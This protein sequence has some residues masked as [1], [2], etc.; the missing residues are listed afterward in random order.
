MVMPVCFTRLT[1]ISSTS[2]I[3]S[4][5]SAEV[6]SSN[7]MIFGCMHSA[8]AM[9][10]RCCWPPESCAGYLCRCSLI[11]TCARHCWAASA[12]SLRGVLRTLQGAST[13]FSNTLRCGNKLKLWNTM[14]TS[15][16]IFSMSFL[17]LPSSMS[18]T[19]I[20]P[21]WCCSSWLMQ[22]ISV[23]LPDPEGPHSTMRSP[24]LTSRLILRSAWYL[25]LYH[26]FTSRKTTA[27]W[28]IREF[29]AVRLSRGAA[30][31]ALFKQ[32]YQAHQRP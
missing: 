21:L 14:P 17:L 27:A 22:R 1:M 5:S 13:Q 25:L 6:G 31:G 24:A 15:H 20:F 7:S 3:I 10:T 4:G 16:R 8:R 9:A 28:D 30:V 18:L 12:A 2:P 23:D 11:R 26:L 32:S 29:P 19:M